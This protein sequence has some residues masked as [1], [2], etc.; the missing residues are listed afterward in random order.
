MLL[1]PASQREYT[2]VPPDYGPRLDQGY[3]G[4]PY[5]GYVA[6]IL[7]LCWGDTGVGLVWPGG[8]VTAG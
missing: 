2:M 7:E 6:A 5:W 8:G 1:V 3:A 4:G